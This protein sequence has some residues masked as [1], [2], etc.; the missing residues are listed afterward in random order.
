M[1]YLLDDKYTF[2]F[3]SSLYLVID[4][5]TT[6]EILKTAPGVVVIDDKATNHF[7]TPLEVS[8]K[9]DVA[10]GQIRQ[11]VSQEGNHGLDI[12][13]CG[14]QVRKGAALNAVQIAELLL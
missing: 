5:D 3:I 6:R 2:G 9:D 12:F 14:D 1:I 4:Q 10:V 11:D 7:P 8:N 13:V